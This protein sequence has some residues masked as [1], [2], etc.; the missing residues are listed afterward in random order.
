MDVTLV[1]N[2]VDRRDRHDRRVAQAER[3]GHRRWI[4]LEH[5]PG[6]WG[7]DDGLARR[8]RPAERAGAD[9]ERQGGRDAEAPRGGEPQADHGDPPGRSLAMVR[10][11]VR[12][13]HCTHAREEESLGREDDRRGE[14]RMRDQMS[15]VEH[16]ARLAHRTRAEP[17]CR[18]RRGRCT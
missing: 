4:A 5:L 11:P 3:D 7:H 10:D 9:E 6:A 14:R 18:R 1:R 2:D 16:E 17:G 15:E 13:E 12:A 8:G